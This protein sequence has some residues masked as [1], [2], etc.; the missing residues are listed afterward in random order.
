M[1]GWLS[2]QEEGRPYHSEEESAPL[3]T[4]ADT[5]QW[6]LSSFQAMQSLHWEALRVACKYMHWT[7][8]AHGELTRELIS[9][10]DRDENNLRSDSGAAA[11][12]NAWI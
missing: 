12:L 3:S 8:R 5:G 2:L 4:R 10:T 6:C 9:K 1:L 11:L 7:L